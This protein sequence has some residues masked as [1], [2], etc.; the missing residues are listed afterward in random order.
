[1]K[2]LRLFKS[3]I[4]ILFFL[5]VLGLFAIVLWFPL[6]IFDGANTEQL[7][8]WEW[9]I[10]TAY[11]II[12]L[13]FLRGLFFLRMTAR[14]LLQNK[15]F[16]KYVAYSTQISG[17]HFIIAGIL[18]LLIKLSENFLQLN[19]ES[20][21]KSFSIIPVFLIMVGLFFVIQ[22]EILLKAID[23]KDENDMTV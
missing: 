19:F 18:L 23:I 2:N 22:S 12:Y 9:I 21:P 20:L 3:L 7:H 16:T 11:C 14:K 8:L 10:L 6:G 17:Y 15:I 13:I 1:M 4:E 5:H